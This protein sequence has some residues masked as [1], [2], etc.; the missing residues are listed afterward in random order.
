MI[1]TPFKLQAQSITLL[2]HHLKNELLTLKPP[3]VH[4]I[5]IAH[6]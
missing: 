4:T 6:G 5:D 1:K 3:K 2:K